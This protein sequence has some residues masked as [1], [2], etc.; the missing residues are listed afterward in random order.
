MKNKTVKQGLKL[1]IFLMLAT[2]LS[3]GYVYYTINSA[4]FSVKKTVAVYVDEQK[5]YHQLLL[6]LQSTARLK[7]KQLFDRLAQRMKYPQN[8]KSGKY[9]IHP[10]MSY[11]EVVRML[12]NGQQAPVK[13]TFNNIRL[14]TDLTDRIGRQMMFSPGDLLNRL[15]DPAV[16][17]SF[18][19]DT[20]TILT[21]FIPN[22]YEIYWNTSMDKFLERMKKEHDRFW[23]KER[24]AKAQALHLSPVEISILASI[25]EEETNSRQEYSVVAGLYLNRLK[26][27]MLLQADPTVKFAVGD[28]TLQ[29]ILNL[30]LQADSPYNTYK[31]SGLPP[32]PIR[33]PSIPAIDGVLNYREHNYLYMCAKE[34]FSGTHNFAVTLEEHNRN[35][36]RYRDALNRLNIK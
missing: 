23:N 8:M 25:V 26:K 6:Q 1:I 3:G 35:A 21:L 31:H 22:T 15:N 18:G 12:R 2:A 13:L 5:D 33:I 34:D 24:L 29:R 19:L 32:G 28:V 27:G 11:L 4:A 16:A 17:A 9:E 10:G 20:I 14:K 30:H 36:Q 7:N